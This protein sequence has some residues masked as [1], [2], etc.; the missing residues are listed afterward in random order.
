MLRHA[1]NPERDAYT[2][3][4]W[5]L[6]TLRQMYPDD[7]PDDE[8]PFQDILGYLQ[9]RKEVAAAFGDRLCWYCCAP[10]AVLR[11]CSGCGQARYAS[12]FHTSF[13]GLAD[14]P[15]TDTATRHARDTIGSSTGA[16][17][18][19]LRCDRTFAFK[20]YVFQTLMR[21]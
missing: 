2:G 14:G 4:E 9:P 17:V 5:I 19:V 8:E 15:L 7:D 12:R 13:A 1:A 6:K 20:T 10:S 21:E 11:K 3:A 16:P 18:R